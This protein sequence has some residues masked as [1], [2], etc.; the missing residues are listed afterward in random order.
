[1]VFDADNAWHFL[2]SGWGDPEVLIKPGWSWIAVPLLTG[3]VSCT[4]QIF[5]AW[6]IYKISGTIWIP[7]PIVLIALTQVSAFQPLTA[8]ANLL[9]EGTPTSVSFWPLVGDLCLHQRHLVPSH[10]RCHQ[11]WVPFPY[12]DRLAWWKRAHG[13]PHCCHNDCSG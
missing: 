3:I 9:T 13:Q 5:F 12:C 8:L 11:N 6:R 7:I 1:M 4:V 10:Q 2:V